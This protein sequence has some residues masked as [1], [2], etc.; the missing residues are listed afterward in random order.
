[1]S[2]LLLRHARVLVTMNDQRREIA[3]GGL[4]ARAGVIE[5][6]GTD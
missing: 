3:G 6:V 2:T 5:A 1:M 4:Y